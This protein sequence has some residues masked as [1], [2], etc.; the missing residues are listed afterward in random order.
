M[1]IVSFRLH[2]NQRKMARATQVTLEWPN[3][4]Y[5]FANWA[6]GS[7]SEGIYNTPHQ[8]WCAGQQD[9]WV[10]LYQKYYL[11]HMKDAL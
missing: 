8:E 9:C 6:M 1:I 3:I 5:P 4:F 7:M 11:A 2:L 10:E